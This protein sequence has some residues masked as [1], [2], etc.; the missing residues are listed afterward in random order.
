MEE[1]LEQ[2]EEFVF[3]DLVNVSFFQDAT[4]EENFSFALSMSDVLELRAF[5]VVFPDL[6]WAGYRIYN[7]YV[8]SPLRG[9]SCCLFCPS[10][11]L[12]SE[13]P[14][15]AGPLPYDSTALV[16]AAFRLSAC[17]R[18]GRWRAHRVC[19]GAVFYELRPVLHTNT[20]PATC[21]WVGYH[22]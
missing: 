2:E 16:L 1:V 10:W 7:G 12:I 20:T 5:L 3:L 13:H 22:R 17:T 11:R 9:N 19:G 18:N 21:C 14:A 15:E 6:I 8:C 4:G